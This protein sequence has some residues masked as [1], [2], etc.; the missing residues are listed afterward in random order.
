[1]VPFWLDKN[2]RQGFV[3][4]FYCHLGLLSVTRRMHYISVG[5]TVR[6]VIT[7]HGMPLV[8]DQALK[9]HEKAQH[10]ATL[11]IEADARGILVVEQ[12]TELN[13]AQLAPKNI[14][15]YTPAFDITPHELISA[16]ITEGGVSSPPYAQS[17]S[18]V[19]SRETAA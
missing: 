9:L 12:P 10:P 8:L 1:M 11:H 15:A 2:K 16:I 13:G 7:H 3:V 14:A 17:L 5:E 6:C 18:A 19:C 4:I